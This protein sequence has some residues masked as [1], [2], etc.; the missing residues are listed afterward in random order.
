MKHL[1][2]ALPFLLAACG[3]KGADLTIAVS[4]VAMADLEKIRGEI[5]GLKGVSD[6]KTG[7]L[8]DGQ[9]TFALKFEGKG[10]DLAARLAT[11]G[12]GL[13]NVKGFDDASIQ[14]SYGGGQAEVD[15][16]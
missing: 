7:Q 4:G 3:S 11:L 10:G 16:A 8:K 13:K 2:L 9:A 6:V 1:L 5:S 15:A 12:S 14:V